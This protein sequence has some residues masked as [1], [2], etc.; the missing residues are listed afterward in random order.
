MSR[1]SVLVIGGTGMLGHKLVQVLSADP[2]MEVHCTVRSMPVPEVAGEG[3]HYHAGVS[4]SA[5]SAPLARVLDAVAPEVVI[6]AVGAIK[7]KDLYA[8]MDETF[9]LNGTLPHLVPLLAGGGAKLIHLS[10]D[11][12]FRGDRGRYTEADEP[13][14]QDLYG[15]SKACGEVDYGGHLTLRTSIIGFELHGHL[16]L[17]SW[18]LS[19]PRG[20]TLRGFT[21]AI[22]S[23]LPTM[24]L[25]R[26]IQRVIR[27]HRELSGLY[28][29]ASEPISKFELLTRLNEALDLGHQLVPDDT[30]EMDR[31]L[32]DTRFR[33]ATGTARPGW[34]QLTGEMVEDFISGGY[35]ARYPELRTVATHPT[36]AGHR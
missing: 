14:V 10:T 29:V 6:N 4:L 13:D 25:S 1:A 34:S 12:V 26:T 28:H 5:G 16:G 7:Q 30:F 31:S 15:R 27:E 35:E 21:R 36:E 33:A 22:Y 2:E 17:V 20:S 8:H 24:T 9:F 32:D 3:V 11:C 23:G 19:Q 18:F